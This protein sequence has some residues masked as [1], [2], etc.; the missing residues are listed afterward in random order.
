[1]I[2][3]N[4]EKYNEKYRAIIVCPMGI[5]ASILIGNKMKKNFPQIDV[6]DKISAIDFNEEKL[7]EKRIDIIITTVNLE[8][9]DIKV[10]K[11]NA[12]LSE[13]DRKKILKEIDMIDRKDISKEEKVDKEFIEKIERVNKYTKGIKELLENVFTI[14]SGAESI[15]EAME[16]ISTKIG[17]SSHNK[18]RILEDLKSRESKGSTVLEDENKILLEKNIKLNLPDVR[19]K[20]EAIKLAGRLLVESGYVDEEYI[21]GMIQREDDLTT[22]LGFGIAIHHGVGEA[23]KNIKETGIVVLQFE[24]GVL[25][26]EE[27]AKLVVGIAGV[28]NEHLNI[29]SNIATLIEDEEEFEKIKNTNNTREILNIFAKQLY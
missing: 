18:R 23:K 2:E 16:T 12:L 17:D 19:D 22:Y 29:L 24:N 9:R 5:G 25:F 13:K 14:G 11:V 4:T 27:K 1:M 10:V 8:V 7:K 3:R 15:T 6:I 28:G 21:D 26:G 20:Y